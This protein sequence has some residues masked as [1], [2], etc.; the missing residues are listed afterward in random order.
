MKNMIRLALTFAL[1][2]SMG[3]PTFATEPSDGTV[4]KVCNV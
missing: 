4:I 1:V 3:I 2:L